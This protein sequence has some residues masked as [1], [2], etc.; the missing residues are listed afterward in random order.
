MTVK[1]KYKISLKYTEN[2]LWAP[3]A[4]F[5]AS[6]WQCDFWIKLNLFYTICKKRY[7]HIKNGIDR[8]KSWV[9]FEIC[10]VT[11]PTSITALFLLSVRIY[12]VNFIQSVK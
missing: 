11:I 6:D 9:K 1:I 8:R 4:K 5:A 2:G 10:N 3:A 7:I 12:V